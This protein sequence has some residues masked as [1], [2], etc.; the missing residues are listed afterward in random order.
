MDAGCRIETHFTMEVDWY[1]LMD[2]TLAAQPD[3]YGRT[4]RSAMDKEALVKAMGQKIQN[5]GNMGANPA[6][7]LLDNLTTTLEKLGD[8]DGLV[9]ETLLGRSVNQL[10]VAEVTALLAW[11]DVNS[12]NNLTPHPTAR[13]EYLDLINEVNGG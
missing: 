11:L 9:I 3:E 4:E 12:D 7:K 8:K 1:R 10:N 6:Q 5:L 13:K 2:N